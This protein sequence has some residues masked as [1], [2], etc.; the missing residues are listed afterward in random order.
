MMGSV[1]MW[2]ASVSEFILESPSRASTINRNI[3]PTMYNIKPVQSNLF[4]P[5][6]MYVE[7]LIPDNTDYKYEQKY[8]PP[9]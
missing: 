4:H 6:D 8:P 2:K 1:R 5:S 7:K 9:D 3:N